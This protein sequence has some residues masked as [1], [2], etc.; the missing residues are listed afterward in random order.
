MEFTLDDEQRALQDDRP[1]FLAEQAPSAYVRSMLDDDTATRGRRHRRAVAAARRPRLGR[2]ARA[3][4]ARRHRRRPARGDGRARGDGPAAAPGSVP[5]V[6][7]AGHRGRARGSGWTTG[8]RRSPRARRA[9]RSRST[10]TATA[11]SSTASA[12][13]PAASPA[14]WRLT[15][16]EDGGARRPLGRLGARARPAPS[17]ASARSCS[18]DPR[19][20]RCAALDVTR[21]IARLELDDVA[22]RAGR[23]GRRP[24]R[25]LA[26]GRR[27]RRGG[28]RAP[29]RSA[30]CSRPSTS[31]SSTRRCACSSI[32]RSPRSRRSSTRPPRCSSA[33]SC[34]GS[35]CTTRPGRPT[36]TTRCG[37]R[38]RPWPSRSSARRPTTCAASA[39]QIHGGVGFT[40][41]CDAHLHYRRAKQN[42]LLLGY[43]GT[44]H[45][46]GRRPL[47]GDARRHFR[48]LVPAIAWI[49]SRKPPTDCRA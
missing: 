27:R 16:D 13:A 22:G 12:P 36:S 14:Q 23:S 48:D 17:R 6:G 45:Q 42:D 20:S 28:A 33:S 47:P 10:R 37:P 43:H 34:R 40:W 49:M 19:S 32:G 24:H 7:R 39:I 1:P 11:T 15:G 30:R 25:G 35:A 9:A 38:R 4:G 26:S 21:R 8:W 5:V 29:R 41:D 18:S 2:T 31:P 46:Q 3:R 44:W